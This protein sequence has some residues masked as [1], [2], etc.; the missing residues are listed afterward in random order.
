MARRHLRFPGTI[1]VP[2]LVLICLAVLTALA[3]CGGE[4]TSPALATTVPATPTATV[5]PAATPKPTPGAQPAATQAPADTPTPAQAAATPVPTATM[6]P[7]SIHTATPSPTPSPTPTPEPASTP[8]PTSTPTPAPTATPTPKPSPT[9]TPTPTVASLEIAGIEPLTSIGE[10]VKVSV[11]ARMSDGSRRQIESALVQWQSS[12][13]WVASV[14]EDIVTAV[15]GGNTTI[16][17]A[18]EGRNA[19]ADVSVRISTRPTG[20]VRALYAIP[21]DREFRADYSAGI[22][23]AIVDVQSWYRRELVFGQSGIVS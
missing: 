19:K 17:A 10:T 2:T 7:E 5:A 8:T 3:A 1:P 11:A 23:N 16:T 20:T 15:G 21:S 6:T 22:A 13:P 14:S 4:Q 9:A 12:D 18:Y